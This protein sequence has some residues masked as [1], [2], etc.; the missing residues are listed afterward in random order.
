MHKVISL[1]IIY[2]SS[3]KR[4]VIIYTHQN[5]NNCFLCIYTWILN[6]LLGLEQPLWSL[7]AIKIIHKYKIYVLQAIKINIHK[8][9]FLT[10]PVK[11]PAMKLATSQLV[12]F[13]RS[14]LK[15]NSAHFLFSD[16]D[17]LFPCH[18]FVLC[19]RRRVM[20]TKSSSPFSL[21]HITTSLSTHLWEKVIEYYIK[22]I[23]AFYILFIRMSKP[24]PKSLFTINSQETNSHLKIYCIT[25]RHA[26]T[27]TSPPCKNN[28][29]KISH[30][31]LL[32]C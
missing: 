8:P 7:K 23:T 31:F 29:F 26:V 12:L 27:S 4:L 24:R 32:F 5:H 30:I 9:I 11:W 25:A 19:R 22:T 18:L 10:L 28:T 16:H 20:N 1:N 21:L 2:L 17:H 3:P 13:F 15:I 6:L 14:P